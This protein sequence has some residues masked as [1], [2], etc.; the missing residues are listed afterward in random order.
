MQL[1]SGES[2]LMTYFI[3]EDEAVT[4][5]QSLQSRGFIDVQLTYVSEFPQQKSYTGNQ[6]LS[7]KVLGSGHYDQNYGPLLA[8]DPS[9]SGMSSQID[10]DLTSSYLVTVVANNAEVET[11]RYILN[12]CYGTRL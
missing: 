5:V 4:A 3:T 12:G 2:S 7:S 6:Y 10:S 9:V 8:A 1:N 11:A